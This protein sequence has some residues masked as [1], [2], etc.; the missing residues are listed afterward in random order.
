MVATKKIFLILLFFQ[1]VLY[2]KNRNVLCKASVNQKNDYGEIVITHYYKEDKM[3]ARMILKHIKY[4]LFGLTILYSSVHL[5]MVHENNSGFC[6]QFILGDGATRFS[7]TNPDTMKQFESLCINT[8]KAVGK[9]MQQRYLDYFDSTDR[10]NQ[11]HLNTLRVVLISQNEEF[12]KSCIKLA[13]LSDEA[14]KEEITRMSERY[15]DYIRLLCLSVLRY[16]PG[17][18]A[19]DARFH[20][21]EEL[22]RLLD[23]PEKSELLHGMLYG[24][25][26]AAGFLGAET[27]RQLAELR[28]KLY[29]QL[30]DN[31][32]GIRKIETFQI[33]DRFTNAVFSDIYK[34]A[35]I[36]TYPKLLSMKTLIAFIKN[37][38]LFAEE[39]IYIK[40]LCN[41]KLLGYC[42]HTLKN[43]VSNV[44]YGPMLQ[45][46]MVSEDV[47]E[48]VHFDPKT[49]LLRGV[50]P[51]DIMMIGA[52][53]FVENNQP[54]G[55]DIS[56]K[57]IP[58]FDKVMEYYLKL[59]EKTG[60]HIIHFSPVW[61]K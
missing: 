48:D 14:L 56:R 35:E 52:A 7:K 10:A 36:R 3:V 8:I 50:T 59:R 41:K 49:G 30:L 15:K 44:P 51:K 22:A 45:V 47:K 13:T 31:H 2:S 40:F 39:P 58:N 28:Y 16:V 61:E 32:P 33:P 60:I 11:C 34:K 6:T 26:N 57:Y 17:A 37:S 53:Y 55:K 23:M 42:D 20:S 46:Y 54:Q 5:A 21:F 27:C 12:K 43:F 1:I 29:Q 9:L 24:T 4:A 19:S 18:P 38:P 25:R